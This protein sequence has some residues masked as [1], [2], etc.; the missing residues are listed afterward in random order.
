VVRLEGWFEKALSRP[1]RLIVPV[2]LAQIVVYSISWGQFFCGDSLYYLS[3]VTGNWGEVVG[4]FLREDDVGQYRP[5]TYPVFSYL[6]YPLGGLKPLVYHWMGLALHIGL[7]LSVYFLLRRLIGMPAALFGY[8]FFALHTTGYFITYDMTFLPDWMLGVFILGLFHLWIR[9]RSSGRRAFYALALALFVLALFTK[10]TALMI[11]AALFALVMWQED[12][13]W[14]NR[15]R[16]TIL[17]VWPFFAVS[18][19]YFAW[20]VLAK[21]RLYPDDPQ[22]P[23]RLTLD[24]RLLARKLKFVGWIFNIDVHQARSTA[25]FLYFALAGIQILLIAGLL[26]RAWRGGARPGRAGWLL[27]SA[28]SLLLP[29]L[30]IA[31]PPYEHHLYMPLVAISAAVGLF[32]AGPG[33]GRRKTGVYQL[34]AVLVLNVAL[35]WWTAVYFNQRSWVAHGSRVARNALVTLKRH[36]GRLASNSVIHL[37]KSERNSIWYFDQHTLIRLF[38]GEPRLAMRFEDLGEAL[39]AGDTPPIR[40]YFVYRLNDGNFER[41]DD[42]W[43]SET[44]SLLDWGLQGTVTEDRSQFFPDFNRFDTP[45]GRRVFLH[46]II[47]LGERRRTLV[48]IAGTRLRVPLPHIEPG[49]ELHVGL[50]S[51]FDIGDGFE[52]ELSF[53]RDGQETTLVRQFLNSA[54]VRRDRGWFDY[55]LDLG[56]LT[57]SNYFL[58]LKCDAGP[59]KKTPGDWACWSLLNI[60]RRRC[61]LEGGVVISR[62]MEIEQ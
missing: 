14:A 25:D 58:I 8:F 29:P 16:R 20:L 32:L 15:L 19:L 23:F 56:Q 27:I 62:T 40:N 53:E 51:A 50:C 43:K 18:L 22:H 10:E 33:S 39:P 17:S 36:H 60:T 61:A 2:I 30:I 7:S 49:S 52:A 31:E 28:L 34:V 3:R 9:Y 11:P 44:T 4:N 24:P 57:G 26:V 5:L 55:H 13:P 6:I 42:P 48:T 47:R 37:A 12:G 45:N 54:R 41:L 35:T 46:P 59:D 21:G 1:A 38:F